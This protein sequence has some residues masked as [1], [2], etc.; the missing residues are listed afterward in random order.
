MGGFNKVCLFTQQCVRKHSSYLC[1]G[2]WQQFHHPLVVRSR[3]NACRLFFLFFFSIENERQW[4]FYDVRRNPT[5]TWSGYQSKLWN[6]RLNSI[7]TFFF[8]YVVIDQKQNYAKPNT[9]ISRLF[10]FYFYFFFFISSIIR[11]KK[12]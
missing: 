9:S 8:F 11:E 2:F 1:L 7:R 10:Q 5:R 6:G 3:F 12:W 4:H